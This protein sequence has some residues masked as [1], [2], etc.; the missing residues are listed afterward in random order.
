MNTRRAMTSRSGLAP[1]ASSMAAYRGIRGGRERLESA[2][3]DEIANVSF[4]GDVAP[5]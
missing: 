1:V 4:F 3:R 2:G 5:M